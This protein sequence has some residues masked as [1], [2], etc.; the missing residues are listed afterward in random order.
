MCDKNPY[1]EFVWVLVCLCIF[2]MCMITL[3]DN[4]FQNYNAQEKL[5][6]IKH[7]NMNS[8]KIQR[9]FSV[10]TKQLLKSLFDLRPRP[11]LFRRQKCTDHRKKPVRTPCLTSDLESTLIRH[12]PQKKP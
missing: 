10:D 3:R 2:S 8:P 9:N 7:I 12:G 1:L 6:K 11:C 4:T 5:N